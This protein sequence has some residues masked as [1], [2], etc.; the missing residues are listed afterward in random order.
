MEHRAFGWEAI[1]DC[2]AMRVVGLRLA[3]G[4]RVPEHRN[5]IPVAVI[6]TEGVLAFSEGEQSGQ[7]SAGELLLVNPGERHS[8]WA[9][10]ATSAYLVYA[11]LPGVRARPWSLRRRAS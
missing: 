4:Q 11:G 9:E 1:A 6:V 7:A 5:A 2:G 8:Y 10:E 3:A